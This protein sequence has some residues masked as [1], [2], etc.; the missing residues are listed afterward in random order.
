MMHEA[1]TKCLVQRE[2]RTHHRLS[3]SQQPC[4]DALLPCF[5]SEGGGCVVP[6]LATG[7]WD[8]DV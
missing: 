8:K 7:A 5:T 2:V 1:G 4:E 6:S 3:S